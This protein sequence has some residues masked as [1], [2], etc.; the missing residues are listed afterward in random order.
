MEAKME[1]IDVN[2]VKFEVKVEANKFNEALTRAYKK[3]VKNFNVPG[4]RKGKV[5]M[6]VV[7]QYY[8]VG[9]LLEDAVNFAIDGSYSEV[10]KE[11]N[12]IPVDY[13][14]IDVVEVGEGKD[15]VYTAEVT[16]YPEVEL[17]EYKGLS[18]EKKTYEVTEEEVAKKLKEMQE[19]NARVESKEEGTVENGN[20]AVIDFKGF[21]DGEAFQGGEGHDYS[22]EIGSKTFIDTF[23]EQLVGAKVNDTVEVN[24]T[25]PENYGKEELNG[26]PAKFEV[27]IKEIKVKELPELDD[28]FAKETS[29]FDTIA[30]LKADITTKLEAANAERADR[31]F[32][33]A[34]INA[35]AENAKVEIPAVMVEKEVD[36][37]VQ[38]LQQRLQYQGLNLEQYFQFTGTDEEKMREYMRE[39]AATKVKV[40]LVLEAV[41][42]AENIDA[43]EEEIKEKA[44]EVAKM[45][46]ASEDDKMVELLMQ[47]QQAALRS[48][49]IT[50]KAVKFLLENN[51]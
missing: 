1:K 31:E 25:F 4:F 10:L 24:V 46:S 35:V 23:E 13:P 32:E 15:F 21:V 11:N 50:N 42:K 6:N 30:E 44:V 37:M 27:T 26:K 47:S 5:P 18:V 33:E 7:K 38:N 51:K 14:K 40:D 16:V 36:K 22:L 12:I 3:N 49:V 34:V 20:I 45:Y 9:V 39:N 19:K 41:E 2:V 8:G 17:G 28:E 43:T 48:D 29:E